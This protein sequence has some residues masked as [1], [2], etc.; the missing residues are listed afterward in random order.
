M[1]INNVIK[2]VKEEMGRIEMGN[3][4]AEYD[5]YGQLI[6]DEEHQI[7]NRCARLCQ[8]YKL[9]ALAKY[10]NLPMPDQIDKKRKLLDEALKSIEREFGKNKVGKWKNKNR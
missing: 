1:D 4:S 10:Y 8:K 6:W 2:E 5:D 7:I 9:D 3:I